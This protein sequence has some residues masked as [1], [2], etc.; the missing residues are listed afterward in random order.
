MKMSPPTCRS[1]CEFIAEARGTCPEATAIRHGN[2]RL[3]YEELDHKANC[4]AGYLV[5]L[6]V[7]PGGTVALCMERSSDWIIAAL[8]IMRVGA[9]YLPLDP[10]WPDSRL[11][12]AVEDSGAAALVAPARLFDR[13]AINTHGI[14][15]CRDAAAIAVSP[16]FE[17]RPI[18]PESLAYVI[19][20]SGSTG[21]PKGVEITHA[22]LSHLIGWHLDAFE[23]TARDCASHLAGLGFD[24]AVWE[25]WPNLCVGATL[26]LA[27]DAVRTSPEL[28]QQWMI[29][30]GVTIGFVPTV[31]AGPMM[32]MEWP[33]DTTLRL[34]LTGGDALHKAPAAE[35]PFKVVNN[36]GPTECTV[37]ATS[38]EVEPGSPGAPPIGRAI[39]GAYV[40]LLD[41]HGNQVA[42]GDVGEI[43]VGGNGVGRGYRNLAELTERNFVPDPFA[44]SPGGRMYRT[45]DRGAR[46]ADGQIEFHGRLDRQTKIRGQRV[47]LDE[48][49]SILSRQ[50]TVD[51]AVA[52]AHV[53]EDGENQLVAYVLLKSDATVPTAKD[54]QDYLLS[55]LPQYMVP[56]IF[57]RLTALPLSANGKVDLALLPKP[58]DAPTLGKE[59]VKLAASP[60]EEKLLAI[61]RELLHSNEIVA[62]DNFF[63]AGG[64]S[65]LGMQLIIRLRNAF[66]EDITLQ[67]LFEAPT[68]ERLALAIETKRTQKQLTAIWK[69]LLKTDLVEREGADFFELGGTPKLSYELRNRIFEEFGRQFVVGDLIQNST[70]RK[71][72]DLIHGNSANKSGLP[73]GVLAL[74]SGPGKGILWLYHPAVAADVAKMVGPDLPFSYV[75]LT[76]EDVESLG[77]APSFQAIAAHL[78][79]KILATQPEGPYALGGLCIAGILAYEVA[80]QMRAA[81]HDVALLV[82]L[83]VP[84]V[85]YFKSPYSLYGRLSQPWYLIKRIKWH[86]LRTSYRTVR[87]RVL[88]RFW[89]RSERRQIR[90]FW[91]PAWWIVMRA[92]SR[93]R[94]AKYEVP[95]AQEGKV[96]LLLASVRPPHVDFLPAWKSLVP[97]GLDVHYVQGHRL[98]L[99][100]SPAVCSIADQITSNLAQVRGGRPL[101]CDV[102]VTGD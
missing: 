11:R 33:A 38:S 12:F 96:L 68:V 58:A 49:G 78:V 69:E 65:L 52:T 34:L 24:A 94:P 23:V 59:A 74:R 50:D 47:E 19:Y 83:D 64:H 13:L 72:A 9:A 3:S 15:P 88:S 46:R 87:E 79:S 53:S 43:Y 51:F 6:G 42:D 44:G 61:V 31:H 4:F 81:G 54:L 40:Y 86:G 29:R 20:T 35:L 25:I 57:V 93:Y 89:M 41:E 8:G 76:A 73:Q 32:A 45:G 67:Q 63:L 100:E 101:S 27:E 91:E 26:C 7:V 56:G 21:V 39:T 30:E 14:D 1:V 97:R 102:S 2:R 5:K 84:T 90:E 18:E 82:L 48:I 85:P 99:T 16:R 60:T 17:P 66:G 95:E 80:C 77:N 75:G 55:H 22:N 36:Y 37:V 92:V 98:N 71:Q 62:S 28:I 70:I 10:A